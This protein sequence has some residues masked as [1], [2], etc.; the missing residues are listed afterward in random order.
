MWRCHNVIYIQKHMFI[1]LGPTNRAEPTGVHSSSVIVPSDWTRSD[2][3]GIPGSEPVAGVRASTRF[4]G[5]GHGGLRAIRKFYNRYGALETGVCLCHKG[6]DRF[7]WRPMISRA[8]SDRRCVQ[9][10]TRLARLVPVP[11]HQDRSKPGMA[12][13]RPPLPGVP[14]EPKLQLQTQATRISRYVLA[15]KCI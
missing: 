6:R 12:Q 13:S 15:V 14:H 9:T 11:E 3:R 5:H 4:H 10:S 7:G 2:A 8:R 1:Y